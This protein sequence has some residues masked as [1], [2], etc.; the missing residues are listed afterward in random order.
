[1]NSITRLRSF[2]ASPSSRS[3]LPSSSSSSSSSSVFSSSLSRSSTVVLPHPSSTTTTGSGTATAISSPGHLSTTGHRPKGGTQRRYITVFFIITLCLVAT[4][5]II[6]TING[7]NLFFVPVSW[8]STSSS[9]VLSQTTMLKNE[10]GQR[11]MESQMLAR[12]WELDVPA[13]RTAMAK[14]T[15]IGRYSDRARYWYI[16]ARDVIL[17]RPNATLTRY[18]NHAFMVVFGTT[19]FGSLHK[20]AT[21]YTDCPP[22]SKHRY[23]KNNEKGCVISF[24]P[25]YMKSLLPY[26]DVVL[27]HRA[28][29]E[30]V[31][32]L[33]PRIPYRKNQRHALLAAEHFPSM[34][35]P[36]IMNRFNSEMSFRQRSL[37]RDG[38]YELL[39]LGYADR[40]SFS[41]NTRLTWNDLFLRKRIPTN[42]R[43]RM[44]LLDQSVATVTWASTHCGSHSGRESLIRKLQTFFPVHIFGKNCLA[45]MNS[46][47]TYPWASQTELFRNYKFHL[48]LENSRCND[49]VTEK[50][51]LALTRGQVPVYL[52]APN[53]DEFMPSKDAYI[54][55]MDYGSVKE[56]AD[57]LIYLDTHD[58]EYEKY[59]AWRSRPIA[60]YGKILQQII[61]ETLP[62]GNN[63]GPGPP[64][65]AIWYKC[66]MCYALQYEEILEQEREAQSRGQ[67]EEEGEDTVPENHSK[68]HKEKEKIKWSRKSKRTELSFSSSFTP[69]LLETTDTHPLE[70]VPVFECL[71]RI[72][73]VGQDTELSYNDA[74]LTLI[75]EQ[76]KLE[77]KI[78]QSN[79]TEY[80]LEERITE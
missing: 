14:Y 35:N 16:L 41:Y 30:E 17:K 76:D 42:R 28:T 29:P 49:Y 48:A 15:G 46:E 8:R 71:S 37:F 10:N 78:L 79:I 25:D 45:N 33:P 47:E 2:F 75:T 38:G 58:E 9:V 74:E 13:T 50:I 70:P 6:L 24:Y 31:E 59:F 62:L 61:A 66:S 80:P 54:N 52:G 63:T 19:W 60:T 20:W 22:P 23:P 67:E 43:F 69:S 26:A 3:V 18:N 34:F 72:Q 68:N 12:A 5:T 21:G 32:T 51:F 53:I 55:V 44:R 39:G 40:L 64:G 73:I 4:V 56:L 7:H 77:G 27:Y 11:M 65:Q 1:M 57:Y 36:Q